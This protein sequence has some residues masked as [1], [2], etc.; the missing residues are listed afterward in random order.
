MQVDSLKL[1]TKFGAQKNCFAVNHFHLHVSHISVYIT[2]L[3]AELLEEIRLFALR[4][5][6]CMCACVWASAA[7]I[8]KFFIVP[9][10]A[11]GEIENDSSRALYTFASRRDK[12]SIVLFFCNARGQ[13]PPAGQRA[14]TRVLSDYGQDISTHQNMFGYTLK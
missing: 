3:L 7:R 2:G 5:C 6:V 10:W 13:S 8:K 12:D 11:P 14:V 9:R 4:F 1:L